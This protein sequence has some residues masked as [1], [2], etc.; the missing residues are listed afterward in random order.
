MGWE[1]CLLLHHSSMQ[2]IKLVWALLDD[3]CAVVQLQHQ[4]GNHLGV[5]GHKVD[6]ATLADHVSEQGPCASSAALHLTP[7]CT[8][9]GMRISDPCRCP[10]PQL[11]DPQ[12]QCTL[13]AEVQPRDLTFQYIEYCDLDP[14][15][16]TMGMPDCECGLCPCSSLGTCVVNARCGQAALHRCSGMG[17]QGCWAVGTQTRVE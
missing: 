7:S 5:F 8:A 3:R 14:H 12:P 16:D 4:P 9:F 13:L 1:G 6:V 2:S 15:A 10:K 17:K 11:G